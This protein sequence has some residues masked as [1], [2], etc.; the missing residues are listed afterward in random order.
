MAPEKRNEFLEIDDSEDEQ[1]QGYDSDA[2]DIRKGG[3]SSKRRRILEQNEDDDEGADL[4]E[5][6]EEEK[7]KEGTDRKDAD[8]DADALDP[9]STTSTSQSREKAPSSSSAATKKTKGISQK[10]LLATEKAMRQSGVIYLSRIPPYMKPQKLRSLL[11]PCGEINRIFLAPEDPAARTRRVKA[12]GNKK[13]LFT[14]GWV[15]FVSKKDAKLTCDMLNA[16][17]IGGKKGSYYCDDVWNMVYLKGFKWRH[18]TEQIAAEDAERASRMRAEISRDTRE[19]KEFVRNV[20]RAKFLDGVRA[21]KEAKKRKRS[22]SAAAAAAEVGA[23]KGEGE[24]DAVA[25]RGVV[26]EAKR[27]MTFKQASLAKRS[28]KIEQPEHVTRVLSK[29]F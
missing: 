13:R 11:T 16:R 9:T 18:L 23:G 6:E 7:Q 26:W 3:R 21:T 8:A 27:S 17:P 15:E 25:E 4:S 22:G 5:E 19:N 2:D 14:E 20:E 24:G 10:N 28:D 1:G 29:I 12:G